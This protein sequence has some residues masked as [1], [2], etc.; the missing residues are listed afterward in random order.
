M[1]E[2][3]RFGVSMEKELVEELDKLTIN[4]NYA[5]RSEAIRSLV[6]K[7]LVANSIQDDDTEVTAIVQLIF[8]YTVQLV[9]NPIDRYASLRLITNLQ[10]H[11]EKNIC[12]K[13]LIVS[14]VCKEVRAWAQELIGQRHVIGNLTFVATEDVFKGLY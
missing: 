6:R 13:I 14:G 9:R 12:M 11:L 2:I 3:I 1:S 5:N 7:E 4:Q 10:Q 8:H